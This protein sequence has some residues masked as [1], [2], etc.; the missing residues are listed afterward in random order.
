[1]RWNHT[2]RLALAALILA[3]LT[4]AASGERAPRDL[5]IHPRNDAYDPARHY[6]DVSGEL[7]Y[8]AEN[9][10]HHGWARSWCAAAS[11]PW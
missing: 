9:D 8:K 4:V 7:Y 11:S 10:I 5:W 2:L 6:K 3:G 1:M